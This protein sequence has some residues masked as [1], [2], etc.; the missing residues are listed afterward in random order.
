MQLTKLT[1]KQALFEHTPVEYLFA[2]CWPP[3]KHVC[4]WACARVYVG[5]ALVGLETL[6]ASQKPFDPRRS[7]HW[8][9]YTDLEGLGWTPEAGLQLE[10]RRAVVLLLGS[11]ALPFTPEPTRPSRQ[12]R[13]GICLPA[14]AGSWALRDGLRGHTA[15]CLPWLTFLRTEGRRVRAWG[16]PRFIMWLQRPHFPASGEMLIYYCWVTSRDR[17]QI[18]FNILH[19][20]VHTHAK[21]MYFE[22]IY[23]CSIGGHSFLWGVSP[24]ALCVWLDSWHVLFP[25]V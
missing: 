15:T 3:L 12:A 19:M 9:N 25:V 16:A 21:Y 10:T 23:L 8:P 14:A 11:W 1:P 17:N 5:W 22:G 24:A 13:P 4:V 6:L 20:D 2:T 18:S 7:P